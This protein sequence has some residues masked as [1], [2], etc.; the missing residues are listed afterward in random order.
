MSMENRHFVLFLAPGF[1]LVSMSCIIDT[2][3]AAN[4]ESGQSFYKW[5][6]T[7]YQTTH[8]RSS[9]GIDLPCIQT[10]EVEMPDVI[11]ICGGD[12]SHLFDNKNALK[13]LSSHGRSRKLIG[14]ISDGAY[15]AAA[16]GLFNNCRSTIHWKCQSAYRERYPHT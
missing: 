8:V 16:A 10:D 5:T 2:L 6:L 4:A 7:G 1:S 15:I 14:S 12:R 13:W 3:R 11:V 9:S